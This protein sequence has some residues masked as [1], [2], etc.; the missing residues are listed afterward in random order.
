L[1]EDGQ[2]GGAEDD[3]EEAVAVQGATLEKRRREREYK[4]D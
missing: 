3:L 1:E 2:E 4:G